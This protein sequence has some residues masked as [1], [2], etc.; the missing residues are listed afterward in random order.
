MSGAAIPD[1]LVVGAGPAG[2]SLAGLL[3]RRGWRVR[4]LDRARFPRP[5]PCG[6]CLNPGAVAA[7]DR[8]ELLDAVLALDPAV[9]L[10]WD[11]EAEGGRAARGRF[12]GGLRGLALPRERLDAALVDA[13][14]QRGARVEEGVHVTGV[15][16][17]AHGRRPVALLHGAGGGPTEAPARVVVGA[18]GLRSVTARAL[19]ASTGPGRRKLSLTLRLRGNGPPTDRGRLVLT[20]AGTAGLAPVGPSLWNATVVVDAGAAGRADNALRRGGR[21][22][23]HRG[24]THVSAGSEGVQRHR[25]VLHPRA[26][27]RGGHAGSG[28][29]PGHLPGR[30]GPER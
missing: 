22:R 19:G 4:V 21:V 1:V 29:L 17:A 20:S 6:E 10:G 25:A 8:M 27:A 2:S 9:L 30:R 11:V 12:G 18:D 26:L 14:R 16:P 5:K 24:A 3:A 7:L 15:R 28:V 23:R 13:A